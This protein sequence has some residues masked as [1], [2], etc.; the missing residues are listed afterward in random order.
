MAVWPN[1]FVDL[2]TVVAIY[3]SAVGNDA[4]LP[5]PKDI[6]SLCGK[7]MTQH[8]FRPIH[9]SPHPQRG[10]RNKTPFTPIHPPYLQLYMFL[11][12]GWATTPP[13]N[14]PAYNQSD[15]ILPLPWS[16]LRCNTLIAEQICFHPYCTYAIVHLPP[17]KHAT[18]TTPF[19]TARLPPVMKHKSTQA[20]T[21]TH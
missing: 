21:P 4:T 10:L 17:L 20:S 11:A 16:K 13:S 1:A 14:P 3:F 7:A 12:A 5:P 8:H 19:H 2:L 15:L 18:T 9:P 6:R